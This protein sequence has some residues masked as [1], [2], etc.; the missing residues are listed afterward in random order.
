MQKLSDVNGCEVEK[1]TRD[2]SHSPIWNKER[3]I[4]LTASKFG[5]VCKMRDSTSCKIKVHRMLY[6]PSTT[7]KS[8]AYGIEMEP[9]AKASFE[10]LLQVSVQLCGLYIDREYPYLAASPGISKLWTYI[11]N[12]SLFNFKL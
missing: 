11:Y 12:V 6:K 1:L 4:R 9:L 8:M 3:R 2:Q 7:S 5:E 10:A